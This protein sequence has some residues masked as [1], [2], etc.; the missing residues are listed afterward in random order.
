MEVPKIR[1]N[2][3]RFSDVDRGQTVEVPMSKSVVSLTR[4]K[5]EGSLNQSRSVKVREIK[6]RK[7]RVFVDVVSSQ[8]WRFAVVDQYPRVKNSPTWIKVEMRGFTVVDQG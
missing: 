6:V 3:W 8:T 1:V 4:T 7:K 2:G 5:G